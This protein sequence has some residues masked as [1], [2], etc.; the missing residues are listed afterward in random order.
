MGYFRVLFLSPLVS[1]L[2]S[3]VS[4]SSP[5]AS[6]LRFRIVTLHSSCVLFLY[7]SVSA[8]PVAFSCILVSLFIFVHLHVS[9]FRV[10]PSCVLVSYSSSYL[11]P[12]YAFVSYSRFLLCPRVLLL[13]PD[14]SS[15]PT[16]DPTCYITYYPDTAY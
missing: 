15:C 12:T 10:I 3:S 6:F 5:I 7:P 11:C 8:C 2:Q 16:L 9:S 4:S 13:N 1:S 14:V